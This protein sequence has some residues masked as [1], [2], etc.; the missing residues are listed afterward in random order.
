MPTTRAR[1]R[2]MHW[3][4][5]PAAHA[6]EQSLFPVDAWSAETF[7]SELAL[8]PATRCYVVAVGADDAVLGYAGV[9]VA[10][11]DADVQTVAVAPQAQGKGV[12]AL[13]LHSLMRTAQQR[14]ATRLFLEVRSDNEPALGLYDREGF[15]RT[16]LRRDY[17]GSGVDA[18]VMRRR[19]GHE[20]A[21]ADDE[22][23]APAGFVGE[24]S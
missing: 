3:T 14:G 16:G 20:A 5:V 12:G 18:V 19:L 6:L 10:G 9:F 23:S 4:D 17:Y 1:I 13:L 21:E 22:P 7:W 24:R 11:A 8:V 2:S 15:E